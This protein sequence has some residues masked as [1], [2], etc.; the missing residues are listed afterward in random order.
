MK[1]GEGMRW[2]YIIAFLVLAPVLYVLVVILLAM[3]L[4]HGFGYHHLPD[5][6]DTL[7][8]PLQWLADHVSWFGSMYWHTGL[9][10]EE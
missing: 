2:H 1:Q 8:E 7:T 4:I 9:Y 3:A 6:V 10:R 5:F